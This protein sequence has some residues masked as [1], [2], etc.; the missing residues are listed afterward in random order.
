MIPY[1]K[2]S[3]QSWVAYIIDANRMFLLETAGDTGLLAGDMRTQLQSANTASALLNGSFVI[4]NQSYQST[5]GTVTGFGSQVYQGTG[6]GTG[7]M[8]MNQSYEDYDGAYSVGSDLGTGTPSLDA[9]NPGRATISGNGTTYLY[10]FNNTSAFELNLSSGYLD[11]G[12][13]EPQTQTT[14]TAGTYMLGGLP[15]PDPD[16]HGTA[17]EVTLNS[18]G[19]V[20]GAATSAGQNKFTW[21]SPFSTTYSWDSSAPGTG[22]F[23]V[24]SP[25]DISCA[26]ISSTKVVCTVQADSNPGV[27]VFQR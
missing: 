3:G 4:Y 6:D 23:L 18:N 24:A 1:G 16:D 13:M 20:S 27:T 5:N 9:S 8:T 14:L 25:M 12:W 11:S 22:T 10:F 26:V 17:G 15:R 2:T 7:N 19:S 21:D